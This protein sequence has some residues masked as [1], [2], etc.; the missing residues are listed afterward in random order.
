[1]NIKNIGLVFVGGS[2]GSV[3]RYMVGVLVEYWCHFQFSLIFI[4][5]II[6][7]LVGCFIIGLLTGKVDLSKQM[8]L[9]LVTGFCGGLT[10]FSAFSKESIIMIQE[11]RLMLALTYVVCSVLFG[12]LL[13]WFGYFI[14]HKN[15][16]SVLI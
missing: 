6:V 4:A 3:C 7:N 14:T 8:N 2:I 11:N 1:M 12:T 5:T 15:K 9:L 13:L 10:T 16:K